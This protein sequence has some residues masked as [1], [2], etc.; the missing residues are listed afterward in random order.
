MDIANVN[1]S[2]ITMNHKQVT[3]LAIVLLS[4][5]AGMYAYIGFDMVSDQTLAEEV[6]PEVEVQPEPETETPP[7]E[8]E[9]EPEPEPET[10]PEPETE[11]EPETPVYPN[12]APPKRKKSIVNGRDYSDSTSSDETDN[13]P[14]TQEL[15]P[16]DPPEEPPVFSAPEIPLGTIMTLITMISALVLVNKRGSSNF[17]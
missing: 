2:I 8:P 12:A 9:T 7:P 4:V 15:P 3:T 17:F 6:I 10:P 1:V 16:E 14:E 13:P 11:P 5:L